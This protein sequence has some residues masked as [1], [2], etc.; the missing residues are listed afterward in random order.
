M[1]IQK[2]DRID[3]RKTEKTDDLNYLRQ[4]A[5]TLKVKWVGVKKENLREALLAE[6]HIGRKPL[7]HRQITK[8]DQKAAAKLPSKTARIRFLYEKEY[9]PSVIS[10][11]VVMHITN[12]YATLR[13][14]ALINTGKSVKDETRLKIQATIAAK[15][16]EKETA[17]K[18]TA[19]KA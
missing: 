15:K 19:K 2:L 13:R 18:E 10:K 16:A 1:K 14:L 11:Y 8:N 3:W 9:H 12:V 6:R 7:V 17:L 5:T 4:V